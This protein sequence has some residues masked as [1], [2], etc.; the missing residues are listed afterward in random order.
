MAAVL[1]GKPPVESRLMMLGFT[2]IFTVLFSMGI[3]FGVG[4]WLGIDFTLLSP[5]IIFVLS[6]VGV[7]DT[8]YHC[9][10]LEPGE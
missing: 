1:G 6:G 5:R 4:A 7:D 9:R 3:A 10:F 8:D 2:C